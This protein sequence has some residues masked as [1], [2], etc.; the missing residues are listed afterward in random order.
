MNKK[1]IENIVFG[2]L[3][4]AALAV[5]V[6]LLL[7][8][9]PPES[10]DV[11]E[12]TETYETVST[13]V[14]EQPAGFGV[15]RPISTDLATPSDALPDAGGVGSID[16]SGAEVKT[17]TDIKGAFSE[18]EK[19]LIADKLE[20]DTTGKYKCNINW[21]KNKS[22]SNDEYKALIVATGKMLEDT[23]NKSGGNYSVIANVPNIDDLNAI[24]VPIMWDIDIDGYLTIWSDV[25]TQDLNAGTEVEEIKAFTLYYDEEYLTFK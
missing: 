1:I 14:T 18:L 16:F 2:V 6:L 13:E 8:L 21:Y 7:T 5:A 17:I 23:L 19:K 4:A 3:L 10:A 22:I 24:N 9:K 12:S 20:K 15:E 25:I 11:K